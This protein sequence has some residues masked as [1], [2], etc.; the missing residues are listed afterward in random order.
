M[1]FG[2]IG[3]PVSHSKSPELFRKAFPGTSST[4]T[5][6][7]TPDFEQAMAIFRKDF[8]A[9][10]VTAPFKEK[11]FLAA[12]EADTVTSMIGASNLLV[13]KGGRIKAY[14]TDF[15]AVQH[16]LREE[17]VPGDELAT[18][19]VGCGGAG[20]AAAMAASDVGR[21][22]IVANR[23]FERAEDFCR[24]SGSMSAIRLEEIPDVVSRCSFVIYTLPLLIKEASS[25]QNDDSFVV[26]EANYKDP[27][28]SS[29]R[30]VP[31][32][33]WLEKQ[34]VASFSIMNS[35]GSL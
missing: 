7:E 9:V 1:K 11:A 23:N 13:K 17:A 6:V 19:V 26:V 24:R 35:L 18:L 33:V 22:V 28:I 21:S 27:V 15:W 12:D 31:G 3:Y 5:L 32:E 30:Y 34:A 2:L 20:K 29:P 8:D 25:F 16:I 4:Y 10:N 14:N